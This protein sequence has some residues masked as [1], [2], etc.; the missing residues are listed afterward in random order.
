M[1]LS[2]PNDE[3]WL[4]LASLMIAS[5]HND[6]ADRAEVN[7]RRQ[8]QVYSNSVIRIYRPVSTVPAI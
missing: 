8:E 1:S 7:E 3:N 5:S 4:I 2:A 6:N